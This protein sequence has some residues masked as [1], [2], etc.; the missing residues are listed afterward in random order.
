[1]VAV[2]GRFEDRDHASHV[3]SPLVR[4]LE[5]ALPPLNEVLLLGQ[6][7]LQVLA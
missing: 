6:G 5:R 4:E 2:V 3:V 1:M 7:H